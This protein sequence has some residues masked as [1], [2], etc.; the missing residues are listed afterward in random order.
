MKSP[1]ERY[2][3][4]A[5]Y[6]ALVDT[7]RVL[8]ERAE[9]TPS[10]IREASIMA[11]ILYEESRIPYYQIPMTKEIHDRLHELHAIIDGAEKQAND[12]AGMPK[13]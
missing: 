6:H 13:C 10:E 1:R 9:F 11:S 8:I 2:F 3:N 7:M 4:D 5:A 12:I